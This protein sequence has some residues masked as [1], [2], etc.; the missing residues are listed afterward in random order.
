M[1]LYLQNNELTGTIPS[2]LGNLTALEFLY[3]A[4]NQFSGCIPEEIRFVGDNDFDSLGLPYCGTP[5]PTLTPTATLTAT[6]TPTATPTP[7]DSD[8]PNTYAHGRVDSHTNGHSDS[9]GHTNRTTQA[10]GKT[11][12]GP[13]THS[14][15]H[16][17]SH[18]DSHRLRWS[19][20]SQPVL[21]AEAGAGKV[22]LSW[23]AVTGAVRYELYTWTSADGW[24]RLDDGGLT[25]TS[26]SHTGVTVSTTYYYAIRAVNTEGG[27]VNGRSMCP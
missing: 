3:L 18:A 12:T 17:D 14:D 24:Q 6:A 11:D 1:H 15:S 25:G 19:L 9:Y 21:T 10:A 4:G 26:Y 16:A 13:S 7:G 2:V 23:E 5:T 8:R 27:T 22:E 20:G